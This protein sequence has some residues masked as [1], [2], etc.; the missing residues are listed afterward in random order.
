MDDKLKHYLKINAEI[1]L[2]L[3][4]ILFILMYSKVEVQPF[5]YIHF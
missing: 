1:I 4:Q 5:V 3:L 2:Y